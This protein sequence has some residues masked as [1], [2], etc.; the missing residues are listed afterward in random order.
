M[1]KQT[2]TIESIEDRLKD[3]RKAV[4]DAYIETESCELLI[5]EITE[6]F[7]QQIKE[8]N[9][10]KQELANI[11]NA[12]LTQIN[13]AYIRKD[14]KDIKKINISMS[15]SFKNKIL[16]YEL[17][18]VYN[19]LQLEYRPLT[20]KELVEFLDNRMEVPSF[21]NR[22]YRHPTNFNSMLGKAMEEDNRFIKK[23]VDNRLDGSKIIYILSEWE[24]D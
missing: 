18:Y 9:K 12:G 20:Q 24:E 19:L 13:L 23:V 3:T 2:E 4:K 16:E 15:K 10:K 21:L 14:K 11:I 5:Q 22:E 8:L 7:K 1:K 6:K 17:N